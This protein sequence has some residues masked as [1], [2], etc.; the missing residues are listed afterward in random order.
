MARIKL[1]FYD[2]EY[3][4]EYKNREE[5]K[6]YFAHLKELYPTLEKIDVKKEPE[7]YV[8]ISTKALV[9]LIKAGLV[10]HHENEMPS[11]DVIANWSTT[12]PNANEFYKMLM[13]MVQDVVNSVEQ[14][15]KNLSWEVEEN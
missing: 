14:D 5:V 6:A 1:K 10:E 4:I 8:D 2:K 13:S 7:K 9:L 12:I 15:A 11:D 3:I